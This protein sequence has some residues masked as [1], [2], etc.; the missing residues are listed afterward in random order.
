M[1]IGFTCGVFDLYHPGHVMMLKECKDHCDF[2]IVA[3]N[4]AENISPEINPGKRN[5]IY[6]IEERILILKSCKYVDDVLS[7]NSEAELSEI[8][9][10]K[11]IHIRFMGDDYRNRK[12]TGAEFNLPI[13]YTSRDHGLSTTYYLNKIKGDSL[14]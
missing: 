5:P 7:Y 4:K 2:L 12:I 9:A 8:L 1:R 11:K 13:F 10:L 6:S 3:I 14:I